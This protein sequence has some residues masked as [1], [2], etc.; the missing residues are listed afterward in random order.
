MIVSKIA[1]IFEGKRPES[2]PSEKSPNAKNES[3]HSP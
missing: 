1:T 2:R 3:R